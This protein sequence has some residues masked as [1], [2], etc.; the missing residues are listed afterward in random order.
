MPVVRR[1]VERKRQG[2]LLTPAGKAL[3]NP[4][5]ESRPGGL[6]ASGKWQAATQQRRGTRPVRPVRPRWSCCCSCWSAT[7]A[8]EK[9]PCRDGRLVGRLLSCLQIGMSPVPANAGITPLRVSGISPNRVLQ[10]GSRDDWPSGGRAL[11]QRLACY[12]IPGTL[13]LSLL[14][15]GGDLLASCLIVTHT[16]YG[17]PTTFLSSTLLLSNFTHP[18]FSHLTLETCDEV[19][20][21]AS[22]RS[23]YPAGRAKEASS[24]TAGRW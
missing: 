11:D 6:L 18:P 23:R 2:P 4:A 20:I 22:E 17:W 19:T 9:Q 8:T 12:R 7:V 15:S 5:R 16:C 13:R 21:G 1:E 14:L 10:C 24:R 3:A